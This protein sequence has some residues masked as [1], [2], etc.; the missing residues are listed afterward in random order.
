MQVS[1]E[2]VCEHLQI[3]LKAKMLLRHVLHILR[4]SL[5]LAVV[6]M[7][8]GYSSIG[9]NLFVYYYSKESDSDQN[10]NFNF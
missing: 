6:C 1:N 9:H 8:I 3:K 4:I 5:H 7:I 10:G 2:A